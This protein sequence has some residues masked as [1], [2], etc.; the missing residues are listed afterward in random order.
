[1]SAKVRGFGFSFPVTETT[2]F[3][4][5]YG[6]FIQQSRLR[7]VYQGYGLVADNIKGGFAISQPVGFG[8]KPERT[9]SYEIG[10]KK[11]LG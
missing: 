7:D 9:T 5:Q 10:F 2:I 8:L 1:M 3:H 4:A 11:Q 6:K